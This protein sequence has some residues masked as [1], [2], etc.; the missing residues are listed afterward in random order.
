LFEAFSKI[1]PL[2]SNP[3][4]LAGFVLMLFFAVHRTLLKSGV[5]PPLSSEGGSRA[6]NALLR[7][8]FVIAVLIILAGFGIQYWKLYL[9]SAATTQSTGTAQGLASVAL[10]VGEVEKSGGLV[11]QP[12]TPHDFYHNAQIYELDGDYTK[13]RKAYEAYLNFNESFVDPHLSYQRMLKAQEGIESAR[14]VYKALAARDDSVVVRFARILLMDR[15]E[16]IAALRSFVEDSPDFAPAFFQ[17]SKDYSKESLG[18]QTLADKTAEQSYLQ[19]FSRLDAEGKFLKYFLDKD[20]AASFQADA[21]ARLVAGQATPANVLS[22]PVIMI[23]QKSNQGW[24]ITF[25]I[26]EATREIFYRVGKQGDFR[27]TGMSSLRDRRTG[28]PKPIPWFTLG[29]ADS[30]VVIE[31]KYVD[32]AQVEKGPYEFT[33]EPDKEV[34]R[35]AKE[36]LRDL[37]KWVSFRLYAEHLSANFTPLEHEGV[38]TIYFSV[39]DDS[40]SRSISLSDSSELRQSDFDIVRVP[41]LTKYVAAKVAFVDGTESELRRFEVPEKMRILHPDED[42]DIQED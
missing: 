32:A 16:R 37:P 26:A 17:L 39:D 20:L 36:M 23:P 8:G 35:E 2:L 3:L 33:L 24:S 28:L 7:Y 11:A 9:D 19:T 27:S 1:A 21:K 34:V 4:I 40:L 31:A 30:P 13:A 12:T 10:R 18:E 14:D 5:I 15:Q 38:S 22:N 6:V 42:A 29:N 25:D 41:N